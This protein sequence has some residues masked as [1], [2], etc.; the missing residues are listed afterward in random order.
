VSVQ[1]ASNS[2][3]M[4]RSTDV[5][6]SAGAHAGSRS[7]IPS[8]AWQQVAAGPVLVLAQGGRHAPSSR[9]SALLFAAVI[10]ALMLGSVPVAARTTP[11]SF[12][13]T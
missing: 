13:F 11:F 1:P 5:R 4:G 7:A 3:E 6:V 8:A 9:R 2:V 10:A 12:T